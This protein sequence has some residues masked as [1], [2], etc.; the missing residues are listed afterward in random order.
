[1]KGLAILANERHPGLP[2]LPTAKE[3]GYEATFCIEN[4]WMA[5]KGT[6]QYAIDYFA[7]ALEKALETD[8]V[9]KTLEEGFSTPS[10][11]QGQ[12]FKDK[13]ETTYTMIAPIA[14]KATKK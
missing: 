6:P 8:Y 12:A 1:M 5:P 10:F 4:F 3:M 14:Q 11:L 13:L 7:N 9:K 2:D